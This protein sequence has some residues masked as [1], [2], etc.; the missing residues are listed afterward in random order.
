MYNMSMMKKSS[1]TKHV[2]LGE[3]WFLPPFKANG[4]WV[5]DATGKSVAEAISYLMAQALAE[6]LNKEAANA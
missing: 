3:T 1:V 2:Y 4:L 6:T 5:D